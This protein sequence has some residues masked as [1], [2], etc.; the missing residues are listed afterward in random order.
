VTG[1]AFPWRIALAAAI[2][3]SF[4][5]SGSTTIVD[6]A[7]GHWSCTVKDTSAH[8]LGSFAARATIARDHKWTIGVREAA[9]GSA[10]V[11][12][13]GS[14]Q[15]HGTSVSAQLTRPDTETRRIT[16]VATGKHAISMFLGS[17][18]EGDFAVKWNGNGDV[19]FRQTAS[20]GSPS[21]AGGNGDAWIA[22]C[23]KV[24]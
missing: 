1:I 10:V 22:E 7:V 18:R 21:V 5:G 19:T 3:V 12:L 8:K 24:K 20:N 11:T 9:R 4:T 16:G 13:A 6:L 15:L 2:A 17:T 23:K 14:W